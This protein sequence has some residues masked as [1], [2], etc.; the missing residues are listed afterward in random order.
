MLKMTIF[1][2]FH[3]AHKTL[4]L[5]DRRQSTFLEMQKYLREEFSVLGSNFK[6]WQP[7]RFAAALYFYTPGD[8]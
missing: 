4:T 5:R 6:E 7:L 3:L 1:L 8:N 2:Q